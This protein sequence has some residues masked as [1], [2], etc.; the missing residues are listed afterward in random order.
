MNADGGGDG[1]VASITAQIARPSDRLGE[2]RPRKERL[3]AQP[4]LT[5]APVEHPAD[6]ISP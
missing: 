1:R 5:P 2:F 3:P 6:A 4:R